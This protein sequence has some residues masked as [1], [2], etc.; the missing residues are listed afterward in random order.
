[1][2]P[3]DTI[4]PKLIESMPEDVQVHG[5]FEDDGN[6]KAAITRLH[7]RLESMKSDHPEYGT[8]DIDQIVTLARKGDEP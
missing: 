6:G 1:M 3:W 4:D 2:P 8:L 5:W 7:A